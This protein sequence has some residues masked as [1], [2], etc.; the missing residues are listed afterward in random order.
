M[1]RYPLSMP[2]S[3][4]TTPGAEDAIFEALIMEKV[5]INLPSLEQKLFTSEEYLSALPR[6]VVSI[7]PPPF[8]ATLLPGHPS[9]QN[10]A[11][12]RK[13]LKG[14]RLNV[15]EYKSAYED[16]VSSN[17]DSS[18]DETFSPAT[19]W[20][21]PFT[22][23]EKYDNRISRQE[24]RKLLKSSPKSTQRTR[25]KRK[26]SSSDDVDD[27]LAEPD[28]PQKKEKLILHLS[29]SLI[30][31]TLYHDS[32]PDPLSAWSEPAGM[33]QLEPLLP[34]IVFAVQQTIHTRTAESEEHGAAGLPRRPSTPGLSAPVALDAMINLEMLHDDP[35]HLVPAVSYFAAHDLGPLESPDDPPPFA[36]PLDSPADADAD[37]GGAD[38]ASFSIPDSTAIS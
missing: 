10:H 19:R 11:V 35:S 30:R 14:D 24:R 29:R 27:V 2:S 32:D 21:E 13:K 20:F 9:L 26:S 34:S 28:V 1:F 4:V 37:S 31:D 22:A 23:A 15:C 12:G 18:D 36:A 6:L 8:E 17:C 33:L 5:R 38:E 3:S 16:P 25:A 7:E